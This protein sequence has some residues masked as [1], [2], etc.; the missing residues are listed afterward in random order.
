MAGGFIQGK[1]VEKDNGRGQ[2]HG[3]KEEPELITAQRL[4][5][6]PGEDQKKNGKIQGT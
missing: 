2:R 5:Q 3:E 6:P 4:A 1:D